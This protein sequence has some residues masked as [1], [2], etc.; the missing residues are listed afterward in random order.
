[1]KGQILGMTPEVVTKQGH[2]K[3]PGIE[4]QMA[5]AQR[6]LAWPD[7]LAGLGWRDWCS[8]VLEEIL[9][10]DALTLLPRYTR[11]GE[12]IGT[13]QVDGSTIVCL[14]DERG[15]PPLPPRA[16]YQ[17]VVL[18]VPETEFQ[19]GEL[20]YLPSTRRPDSPYGRSKVESV[21]WTVNLALRQTAA[22][23]AYFTD[24]N[25]PDGGLYGVPESWTPPQ[26]AEFQRLWNDLLSGNTAMRS[27]LRFVPPGT[28]HATKDRAWSYEQVEWLSRVIAWGFGVSPMPIAKQMNRSTSEVQEQSTTESGVRPVTLFLASVGTR[29]LNLCAGCPDVELVYPVDKTEDP[30]VTYQRGIQQVHGGVKTVNEE[31]KLHGLDPYPFDVPP[32]LVTPAGPVFLEDLVTGREAEQQARLAAAE[33]SAAGAEAAAQAVEPEE[34]EEPEEVEGEGEE[35]EQDGEGP[36]PEKVARAPVP[37][38]SS[39]ATPGAAADVDTREAAWTKARR[40]YRER[41][42]DDLAAWRGWAVKRLKKG[43]RLRHFGTRYVPPRMRDAL[44]SGLLDCK[45]AADVQALFHRVTGDYLSVAK[46]EP[47]PGKVFLRLEAKLEDLL[48]T[49]LEDLFPK[50]L[51][52]ALAQ[53]P[54]DKLAKGQMPDLTPGEDVADGLAATLAEAA[55]QGASQ[56]GIQVGF[57]LDAV[58]QPALDYAQARAGE[59]VGMKLVDG[60]WIPNPNS[61][62][63]ISETLR[64]QVQG[65]TSRAIQEGWSPQ[66]LKA[67][68][69]QHFGSWRAET[70]ARTEVGLAAGKGAAEAYRAADIQWVQILDGTGCLPDGHEDGAPK[71]EGTPG[72][73][74]PQNEADGQVWTLDQYQE[75]V[76]GHPNCVRGTVPYTPE[77]ADPEQGWQEPEGWQVGNVPV[78]PTPPPTQQQDPLTMPAPPQPGAAIPDAPLRTFADGQEARAFYR[79]T[80]GSKL[81]QAGITENDLVVSASQVGRTLEGM[82]ARGVPMP[83]YVVMGS[84]GEKAW[85]WY[86]WE[87]HSLH[88]H[89]RFDWKNVRSL[90]GRSQELMR[91]EFASGF[92]ASQTME[93]TVVHEMAH[94]AHL[95]PATTLAEYS[96]RRFDWPAQASPSAPEAERKALAALAERTLGRYATTEPA[97]FVAE[98]WA[99]VYEG[100]TLPPELLE[101]YRG[102]KGAPPLPTMRLPGWESLPPRV[103]GGTAP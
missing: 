82:K 89:H 47:K 15:R 83:Q 16:A 12:F 3:A 68:L 97:E 51:D 96:A 103:T 75:Q 36:P 84:S 5:T 34:P 67:H 58:P 81:V 74:Q 69:E 4:E 11:G 21:I 66:Q 86:N 63:Q 9:V 71:A 98:A 72:V 77:T 99:F 62:W 18:G 70:I 65:L 40:M 37:F 20:L 6:W 76:L 91:A 49:W 95:Q 48:L 31:R 13:E 59:L 22:D 60:Q 1:V 50:V 33:A 19:I 28:Y 102:I 8:Q 17:Q 10:T 55:T 42:V 79:D 64:A 23:L 38:A 46:G 39:G 24:G 92:K 93:S 25:L 30:T 57:R 78:M 87:D 14:V 88:F 27:G 35:P 32:F 73:V 45:A 43:R 29:V 94:V 85:A 41:C 90:T 2:E 26:I 56:A 54:A 7:P 80:L 61:R 100:G 53:L 44:E 52:W 101:L